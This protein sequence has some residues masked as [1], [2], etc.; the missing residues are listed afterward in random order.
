M[1]VFDSQGRLKTVQSTDV[2]AITAYLTSATWRQREGYPPEMKHPVTN[3][4]HMLG[5]VLVDG[6]LVLGFNDVG[7]A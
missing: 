7:T 6:V 5:P 3:L 4:W 1:P 2:A